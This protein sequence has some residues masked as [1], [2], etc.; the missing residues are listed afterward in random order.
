M[1]NRTQKST[2]NFN[3]IRAINSDEF[4]LELLTDQEGTP[5]SFNCSTELK[6]VYNPTDLLMLYVSISVHGRKEARPYSLGSVENPQKISAELGDGIT[7]H[8]KFRLATVNPD[9]RNL[10]SARSKW[11]SFNQPESL[12][13]L[14]GYDFGEHRESAERLWRLELYNQKPT[15]LYNSRREL[16]AR[17]Q[18]TND[19][20]IRAYLMPAVLT[21][22][23]Y[24]IAKASDPD[25]GVDWQDWMDDWRG[26]RKRL[27]IETLPSDPEEHSRWVS[28]AVDKFCTQNRLASKLIAKNRQA[29]RAL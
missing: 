12:I 18:I 2:S 14:L 17:L 11:V 10:F 22:V 1:P 4:N 9:N 24:E 8:P 16:Q 7:A 13:D 6:Q 28:G 20:S 19:E 5:K 3:G 26:F 15:L 21:E 27:G 29:R 25:S 23:L